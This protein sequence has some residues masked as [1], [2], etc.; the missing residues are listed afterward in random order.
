MGK[1]GIVK[2]GVLI[3]CAMLIVSAAVYF[4]LV[5]SKIVVGSISGL[6][7]V[8][9]ELLH[10]Q[11]STITFILNVVLL[12]AGFLFIGKEFGAKTIYTSLLLP[13]FLWI[14]ER[15][16]P[17]TESLT[18]NSVYDLVSYILIIA[19]GQAI[20][21]NVNASS[22][23]LDVIAKIIS[24]YTRADIGKAV[25]IAGMVTAVTS[26]LVYDIG[27]LVVSVLGTYAN[28]LPSITLSMDLTGERNLYSLR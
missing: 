3:T 6:A 8:L 7:M 9:A 5:P 22:G 26:I 11:M 27:T 1:Q 21:F 20:L 15:L 16:F 19:L 24:K 23:G 4:F 25:T 14:F 28:D 12:M 2:E 17:V 10:M 18:G 13:V